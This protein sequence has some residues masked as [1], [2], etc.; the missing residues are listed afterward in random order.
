MIQKLKH[1]AFILKTSPSEL[2]KVLNHID[3][4]YYEKATIKE[5]AN[6]NPKLKHGVV[7]RRILNPSIKRLKIIQGL[8][9]KNILSRMHLPDYA[10]GAAK[11]KDNVRNAKV[12]Q[13]KKFIFTTDL[14]N[15][16]PS[17]NHKAVHKMFLQNGFSPIAAHYLTRITTYKGR[18][19]QG[20]PTSSN[21]ANLVFVP[22]GYEL[23]AFA[24]QH[25][26]TFTSFI[27]DLTFSSAKDFK[28]LIPEILAIIKAGGFAI[29][30]KKTNYKTKLP[31]VTG[32]VVKNNSLDVPHD[33]L[34]EL[35][36]PSLSIA[37][38]QGKLMYVDRVR[39]T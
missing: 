21:L 33:F 10:Y 18:I 39:S 36:D 15:F 16:F 25:K 9:Q 1:L 8:A 35:D 22:T 29:S 19:P 6:G 5:D 37:S 28:H 27:D 26:L 32:V 17:I 13:G 7:Q 23:L 3:C 4:F 34:K 20:A 24:Q 30:H 2:D 31:Q 14:A 11:G 38:R 12:H